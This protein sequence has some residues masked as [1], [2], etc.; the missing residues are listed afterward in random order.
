MFWLF[1]SYSLFC[2]LLFEWITWNVYDFPVAN[3]LSGLF[4]YC[5][6]TESTVDTTL[7]CTV[8]S[9]YSRYYKEQSKCNLSF[10]M[11]VSFIYTP[12]ATCHGMHKLISHSNGCY[13]KYALKAAPGNHWEWC[14]FPLKRDSRMIWKLV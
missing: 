2:R 6:D 14:T 4:M 7:H 1:F 9:S 13:S 12:H 3:N 11:Y 5:Q 10:Y 8:P